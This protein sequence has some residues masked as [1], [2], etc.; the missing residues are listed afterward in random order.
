MDYE[1]I[2]VADDDDDVNPTARCACCGCLQSAHAD[3]GY[4]ACNECSCIVCQ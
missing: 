3:G 4:G 1:L 2:P